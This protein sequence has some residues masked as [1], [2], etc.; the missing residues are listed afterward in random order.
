MTPAGAIHPQLSIQTTMAEQINT[1]I[2]GP[3]GQ[4]QPNINVINHNT[5]GALKGNP[6]PIFNGDRSKSRN[7]LTTFYL[8]RLTNKYNDTMRK[9]YSH[10][11]T[12]LSYMSGPQVD[13]WKKEQLGKLIKEIDDGTQETDEVLW[14]NFIEA[15]KQAYTNTNLREEAY[16]ALCKLHQKESLDEFFAD[17]KRL[18]RDANVVLND[19]GTIELLKNALTGAL[20]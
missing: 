11:T 13:S 8:W 1:T 20:T 16:Q 15:F 10:I 7:F 4:G 2:A 17:F 5:N 12:L 6:P 19:R 18:A 3:E 14:D 9:P